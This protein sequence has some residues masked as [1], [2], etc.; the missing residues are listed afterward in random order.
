MAEYWIPRDVHMC[1]TDGICVWFNVRR[2]RFGGTNASRGRLDQ[3]VEGWP[4][5]A[6]T[7]ESELDSQALAEDLLG[8]GLLTRDQRRGKAAAPASLEAAQYPLIAD[9]SPLRPCVRWLHVWRFISA[10]AMTF[11]TLKVVSLRYAL[12]AAENCKRRAARRGK[13][14]DLDATRELVAAFLWLSLF[15]TNKDLCLPYSLAMLRYLSYFGVAVSLAI[16]VAVNP[17][18]AHCWIQQGPFVFNCDVDIAKSFKPI[19]VI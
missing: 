9:V 5:I 17:F 13:Q 2:D 19:Y 4:S 12:G 18:H 14:G 16:G 1:I 3:L 6:G 15:L 10:V 11:I 8:R 7:A